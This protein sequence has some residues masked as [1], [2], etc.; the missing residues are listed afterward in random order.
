MRVR[1][2]PLVSLTA[3][4]LL[5]PAGAAK[6]PPVDQAARDPGFAAFR[7]GLLKAVRKRDA[8][9]VLRAVSPKIQ[10]GFGGDDGRE[11]FRKIWKLSRPSSSPLWKEL[12]PALALGGT[13]VEGGG[14][15]V[16]VA[17]YVTSADWPKGPWSEEE[18]VGSYV[19]VVVKDA[20][21]RAKPGTDGEVLETLSYDIV[22]R[23]DTTDPVKATS[24]SDPGPWVKVIGPGGK[25]GWVAKRYVRHPVD[26]R[27]SFEK[28]NGRWMMV[29][30][31]AGD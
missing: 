31:G 15:K 11:N 20:R 3:L 1:L 5:V 12:E 17:P 29:F 13:W 28:V 2:L 24:G 4:A 7:N 21:L 19:V 9:V 30:F 14:K 22:K 16:F 25:S 27:A 6:L 23:D 8:A 10:N 18:G 26:F